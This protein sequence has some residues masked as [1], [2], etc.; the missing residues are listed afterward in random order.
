MRDRS[1]SPTLVG[2]LQSSHDA[3][4]T[5]FLAVDGTS[6]VRQIFFPLSSSAQGNTAAVR[7]GVACVLDVLGDTFGRQSSTFC[8]A[9]NR[10]QRLSNELANR[11]DLD[12]PEKV[13]L[14]LAEHILGSCFGITADLLSYEAVVASRAG[15]VAKVRALA[16]LASEVAFVHGGKPVEVKFDRG[17]F[18][19]VTTSTADHW[20]RS[21]GYDGAQLVLRAD[22]GYALHVN[23]D[24]VRLVE[25]RGC[26]SKDYTIEL[27]GPLVL[28]FLRQ[29]GTPI[30]VPWYLTNVR[31]V[32]DHEAA[33]VGLETV[34]PVSSSCSHRSSSDRNDALRLRPTGYSL[35]DYKH[36]SIEHWLAAYLGVEVGKIAAGL[37]DW[38][39]IVDAYPS[40]HQKLLKSQTAVRNYCASR[41]TR[42]YVLLQT[43]EAEL[44]GAIA[45][46]PGILELGK[47]MC[48]VGALMRCF[49][50]WKRLART[51]PSDDQ[52]RELERL[53][54]VEDGHISLAKLAA[55]ARDLADRSRTWREGMLTPVSELERLIELSV[56]EPARLYSEVR[57]VFR[58]KTDRDSTKHAAHEAK[59]S[60]EQTLRDETI[61]YYMLVSSIC[62]SS[63]KA[64]IWNMWLLLPAAGVESVC[65]ELVAERG[66]HR[67]LMLESKLWLEGR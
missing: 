50:K 27:H 35:I 22:D 39:D 51:G 28:A 54:L 14:A 7:E 62:A 53:R 6:T 63:F 2:R 59:L 24:N 13:F 18:V 29:L 38:R 52:R 31:P 12:T 20:M 30:G 43:G 4:P 17:G 44:L 19:Q 42:A 37:E 10:A 41:L 56:S 34:S 40:S 8:E 47:Q 16:A 32:T 21:G 67:S 58:P 11:A 55:L 65:R 66:E 61:A 26:E 25:P 45:E 36:C 5:P 48:I 15:Q 57:R 1:K 23:A 3:I 49:K 64:H 46:R 60:A 33:F 9:E